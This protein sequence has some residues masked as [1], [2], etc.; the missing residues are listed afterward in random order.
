M[1]KE[2]LYRGKTIEELSKMSVDEFAKLIPSR[3]RRKVKRGFTEIEKKLLADVKSNGK[4]IRTHARDMII[5]PEMVGKA[6]K[7]YNGKE[8][9]Q[10]RIEPEMLS[11]RLGE[12]A[13]TRRTV[14]HSAPGIGA[15]RSS[16]SLSVR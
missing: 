2:F 16:A 14:K 3:E 7:V 10:I 9:V 4:D 1:A 5:I 11:H 6:I 15:T 13:L 12:F 8:W